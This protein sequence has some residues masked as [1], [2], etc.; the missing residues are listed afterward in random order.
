MGDRSHRRSDRIA[1][2]T[3]AMMATLTTGVRID[4]LI[5]HA[6]ACGIRGMCGS[7]AS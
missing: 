5:E 6:A 1:S 2:A 3:D 7:S 4:R